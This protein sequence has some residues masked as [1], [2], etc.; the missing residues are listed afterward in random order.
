MFAAIDRPVMR[1]AR[2]ASIS[3]WDEAEFR[4]RTQPARRRETE[5]QV[6]GRKDCGA[7]P[8]ECVWVSGGQRTRQCLKFGARGVG[9][10]ADV[11]PAE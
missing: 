8:I 1:A 7:K 11:K 10:H 4:Q 2:G 6:P 5:R 3:T 9:R